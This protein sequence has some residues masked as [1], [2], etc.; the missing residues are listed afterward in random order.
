MWHVHILRRTSSLRVVSM[1][2]HI[3]SRCDGSVM[4]CQAPVRSIYADHAPMYPPYWRR[5]TASSSIFLRRLVTG[6]DGSAR[7]P[8]S[9][10]S[11]ARSAGR[12]SKWAR[13]GVE[14]FWSVIPWVIQT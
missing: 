12:E 6:F 8:G 5:P 7:V 13:T 2:H 1:I 11:S 10:Q 3:L 14:G 4:D 9:Q